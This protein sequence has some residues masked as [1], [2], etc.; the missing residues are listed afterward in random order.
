MRIRSSRS[1]AVLLRGG[2]SLMPSITRTALNVATVM[3][4]LGLP[5][6][7]EADLQGHED[8]IVIKVLVP[9]FEALGYDAV[10]DIKH[11]PTLVHPILGSTMRSPDLGVVPDAS[12]PRRFGLI[13]DAKTLGES[14]SNW[15]A[16][17]V[18]YC[19][20]AGAR[21]GIL[22][23]GRQLLILDPTR[24]LVEW[25]YQQRI[26]SRDE[27]GGQG[28]PTTATYTAS[29][30]VYAHRLTRGIDEQTVQ[31]IAD[32]CH[33]LIRR[34]TGMA[35]PDR[36]YEFSKLLLT[37]IIDEARYSEG[38]QADLTLTSENLEQLRV[39]RVNVADYVNQLF[40]DVKAEAPIFS[41]DEHISLRPNIIE[42]LVRKL[43]PYRLWVG[44]GRGANL[45]VLG[46]VYERFLQQTMTGQE[47][48]QYF[49]PRTIV[50]MVVEMV[51]PVRLEGILDPACG[52]GGFLIGALA[53]L[54]RKHN[55]EGLDQLR[56]HAAGFRG[57]DTAEATLKLCQVNLWLHGDGSQNAVRADCLD[58]EQ[59]PDF[60][61]QAL[62]DPEEHGFAVILT[63]P[64]FGARAG[65]K[66][67]R[68][69]MNRLTEAWRDQR[70]ELF[71]LAARR[72]RGAFDPQSLFVEL[73]IKGLRKPRRDGQGGRLGIIVHNG[74]LSNQGGEEPMLR[75]MI[76][77]LCVVE[78]I[79]GLPK[80]SFQ[81]YGSNVIPLAML[82]RRRTEDEPQGRI[83]RA[84]AARIGYT[85]GRE[86]YQLDRRNDLP[87]IVD[88][89]RAFVEGE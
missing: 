22:C 8:Q 46:G 83:F 71:E 65:T 68:P 14:L 24:G 82:L 10:R 33:N 16:K 40:D 72:G 50:E 41:S 37:R 84:E 74:L 32:Y 20:L 66:I 12:D 30:Q 21:L 64:P 63:N 54:R 25:G 11:K 86:R 26:P 60:L 7:A 70:V 88:A 59:A 58:G 34:T 35:V 39:R 52:T 56:E 2:R 28:T 61:L 80:G 79:V 53:H 62:R 19:G 15:E 45:D 85:A 1:A 76:R 44:R 48:G 18:G 67:P 75:S 55:L 87:T 4:G 29:Q 27:L 78:A 38:R 6:P 57:V 73:C 43:D 89:Y 51:A 5:V 47:L 36:L 9:I 81:P 42:D 77:R 31:E 69:E 49:T 3:D 13:A 23:N 17:L